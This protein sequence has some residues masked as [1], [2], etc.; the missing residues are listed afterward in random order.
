MS[1]VLQYPSFCVCVCRYETEN[2]ISA[3]ETGVLG[4]VADGEPVLRTS[5][6]YEYVGDDNQRYR[7]EYTADENGFVATVCIRS[8]LTPLRVKCIQCLYLL[9]TISRTGRSSA[10]TTTHST[11]DPTTSTINSCTTTTTTNLNSFVFFLSFRLNL[12]PWAVP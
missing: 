3:S 9:S 6:F 2:G 8:S 1:N 11:R 7:V 5:G 10:N 12:F 4:Q